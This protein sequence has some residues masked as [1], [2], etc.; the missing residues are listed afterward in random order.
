MKKA[1]SGFTI[2]ELLAVIGV[3]AVLIS[4]IAS[5]ATNSIRAGRTKRANVMC[6]SLQQAIAAYYAEEGKWPKDIEDKMDSGTDE[7]TIEFKGTMADSIFQDVVGKGFGKS[8]KKSM[9][10]DASGLF[11]C[12]STA[13]NNPRA[14]GYNFSEVT[15]SSA[16]HRI[17]LTQMAFGYQDAGSGC[18]RRFRVVYNR[19]TD[20]VTVE[21]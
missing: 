2:V 17:G 4:I 14:R 21:M 6:S 12:E 15:G 5:V 8:G 9:L 3:V 18:F 20:S 11:V 16:K 1:R 13:A 10:L 7:D 19:R